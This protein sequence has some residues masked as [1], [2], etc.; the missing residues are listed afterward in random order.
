M[1]VNIIIAKENEKNEKKRKLLFIN[2]C[3]FTI[4][5]LVPNHRSLSIDKPISYLFYHPNIP[6]PCTSFQDQE[7][8]FPLSTY[9]HPP[10][11]P[12]NQPPVKYGTSPEKNGYTKD[13][14]FKKPINVICHCN[15]I[16]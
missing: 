9:S 12:L 6:L 1:F 5:S 11:F 3:A 4:S 2:N 7:S 13:K 8:V 16:F 15:L 14:T 10:A